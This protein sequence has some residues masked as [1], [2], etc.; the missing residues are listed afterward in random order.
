M[1]QEIISYDLLDKLERF[2]PR[3][4]T[5]K[6]FTPGTQDSYGEKTIGTWVN[7]TGLI[8][9]P[10]QISPAEGG[11]QQQPNMTPVIYTHRIVIA[12]YYPEILETYKAVMDDD[13][14]FEIM[15][16]E[17]DSQL[18]TTPLQVKLLIN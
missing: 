4:V 2:F 7:V 1:R 18:K 6:H 3:T 10:C 16:V 15:K 17:N 12:G 11:K 9:L 13:V 8:D 5:I 14:E